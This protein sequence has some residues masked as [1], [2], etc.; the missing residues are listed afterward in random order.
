VSSTKAVA[1]LGIDVTTTECAL[2]VVDA[3]G[4]EGFASLPMRGATTWLGDAS[5]PGF[6]LDQV[7]IMIGQLLEQLQADGWDFQANPGTVS[8]ACRQHDQVLLGKNHEPL[9]P[10]LSW[11]CNAATEDVLELRKLGAQDHVGKIEERFVLPKL[12]CVLRKQPQLRDLIRTVFLTG[13]WIAQQLTGENSLSSSDA[14]SNGLLTQSTREKA[15]EVMTMADLDANWFPDVAASGSVVG[16]ITDGGSEAWSSIRKRLAGWE[17]VAG[18]GDNHASAVGCGMSD[19]HSTLVVSAGTSGTINFACPAETQLPADQLLQFEF[20]QRD[21]LLLLM[22]AGCG[23]WY[24]RFLK[25]HA[26]GGDLNELNQRAGSVEKS[27]LQRVLHD[28]M[29]QVESFQPAWST[30]DLGR[31]VADT[32]FSIALELLLRVRTMIDQ[33]RV[34]EVADPSVVVLTGGLSQSEFFQQVFHEGISLVLPQASVR[35][36]GRRGPLRYK[37][38]AYGALINAELPRHGSLAAIHAGSNRFPLRKCS[39]AEGNCAS[40]LNYLLRAYGV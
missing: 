12:H 25:E 14:L 16:R 40:Q 35:L 2:A 37:T 15:T 18:L 36:S 33:T 13:D 21:F 5:F 39:A 32:Q 6:E 3:E 26:A 29:A 23:D 31:Q 20:Y 9:M 10:A 24:N 27:T 19:D 4:Q 28:D 8:V 1:T 7:P 22:L 38:S 17:F 30:L 34:A 11:Q